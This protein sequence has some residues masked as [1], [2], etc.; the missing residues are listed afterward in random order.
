MELIFAGKLRPI[1]DRVF[2]LA[3]AA[4]AQERLQRGEQRGKIVLDIQP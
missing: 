2:P 1:V 3:Q 4:L